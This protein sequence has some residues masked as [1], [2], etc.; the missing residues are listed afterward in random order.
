MFVSNYFRGIDSSD[1][2]EAYKNINYEEALEILNE[3]F[4]FDKMT[5]SIIEN[6]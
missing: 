5:V 4:D 3:H 6:K 1:Y 2:V